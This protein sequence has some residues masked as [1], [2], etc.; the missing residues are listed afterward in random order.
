MRAQVTTKLTEALRRTSFCSQR[1]SPQARRMRAAPVP[2][3]AA[4]S[5]STSEIALMFRLP[6]LRRVS[7]MVL[8]TGTPVASHRG[9]L[10]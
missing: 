10:V 2:M 8:D 1:K 9:M 6:P 5:P 7:E 4:Y 3:G